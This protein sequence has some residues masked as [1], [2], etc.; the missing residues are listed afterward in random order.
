MNNTRLITCNYFPSSPIKN[1][2][3]ISDEWTKKLTLYNEHYTNVTLCVHKKT[4][5]IGALKIYMKNK[6]SKRE[7]ERKKK[8][9][10]NEIKIN[11]IMDGMDYIVPLWFWFE[12]N[13]TYGLMLKYMNDGYL[14]KNMYDFTCEK[15]IV[16]KILYPL[17]KGVSILHKHKIIHRDLKPEN[18]FIH[19]SHIYI[20]DFG[21]SVLLE[22]NDTCNTLA[23]TITYMAPE[24][25]EKYIE[26]NNNLCYGYEVD[27][28]SLGIITYELF[29]HV[30]PFGWSVYKNFLKEDPNRPEF[31]E[32]C[33]QNPLIIPKNNISNE[34]ENFINCCLQK[35]PSKR[36]NIEQLMNHP[37]IL[38]YLKD[39]INNNT[40]FCGECPSN[41]LIVNQ[42][43]H[44]QQTATVTATSKMKNQ[45]KKSSK[46][47][48][49]NQC[50]TC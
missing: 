31:I 36:A 23:G 38:K 47:C 44:S 45:K 29:F 8:D 46:W 5:Q 22:E 13:N 33:L 21:Y 39:I 42:S 40:L 3:F 10:M 4:K 37:L 16:I 7:L 26:K 25:L 50:I 11:Y 30:K 48:L 28:W 49:K 6:M 35:E 14:L 24:I 2:L 17:L 32:K 12:T 19:N 20:G 9:F 41:E 34:A 43:Y 18:I 27:I 15:D 1:N